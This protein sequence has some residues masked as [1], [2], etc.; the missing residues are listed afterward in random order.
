MQV[1]KLEHSSA[2]KQALV[3]VYSAEC[4]RLQSEVKRLSVAD[5]AT[6]S[7]DSQHHHHQYQYQ[8]QQQ[9]RSTPLVSRD[10]TA[11]VN[12]QKISQVFVV[13]CI[14]NCHLRLRMS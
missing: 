8:Q 9:Q 3:D 1:Q 5:V 12:I 4:A 14:I 10:S 11:A 6:S 2:V 7:E 13:Q